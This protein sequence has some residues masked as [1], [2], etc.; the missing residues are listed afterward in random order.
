MTEP[1]RWGIM[2]TGNIAHAFAS[3]LNHTPGADLVAVGSRNMETAEAFAEEHNIPN[4]H[5]SYAS[6]ANDPAVDIIYIG[7]PHIFHYDNMRLCLEAGKPVLCEKA[8]TI[9]AREAR[10][11]ID[12]AREKNLFLM[13][14][15]W[16]RFTPGLRKIQDMIDE[17]IIGELRTVTADF[18]INRPFDPQHRL[19]NPDLGGGALLD[20]G[21][22]PLMLALTLLGEPDTIVSTAQFSELGMDT[23]MGVMLN[24][25]S[26]QIGAVTAT[27]Q[28]DTPCVATI[29]GSAGRIEIAANFWM[30]QEFT[31]IIGDDA[32]VHDMPF[33][34]NGY[35]YEAMESMRCLREGLIESPIMPHSDTLII[36]ETMD[37][38]RQQWGMTYPTEQ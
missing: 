19:Y 7:T 35:E 16:T 21:I 37:A 33:D 5:D 9:N 34:F 26:G 12:I 13:E 18:G 14:A 23:Q 2:S 10:T 6:L 30:P 4:R 22:Y 29:N 11:V 17:G 8:F 15:L 38:I 3:A 36:M 1:I 25:N 31:V 24:Y 27:L 32:E 20:I 28:S